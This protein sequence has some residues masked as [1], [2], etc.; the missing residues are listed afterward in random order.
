MVSGKFPGAIA[1]A[2]LLIV[3]TLNTGTRADEGMWPFNNV[4]KDEI[5]RRYGFTVTDAWLRKVQLA[6]VRFNNGGSGSFVS[7]DGLVLT[8]N[9]IAEDTLSKLSTPEKDY[10]KDGFLAR[11]RAEEARAPDLELNLLMSIEDVTARVRGATK[12]GM[13]AAEANAAREA[14][15][16]AIEDESNKA[17]GLRSDVV[18]L[19]QGGQYNLYRYKQYTDVR[20]VFAPEAAIGFFGGDPDNFEYPR[21]NL[22][23]A[24]FR[25][26]ENGQPLKVSNYFAWSRTGGREN[27][28]VFVSGNPGS[29]GRLNTVAHLRY[30]RD[31]GLPFQLKW[32]ANRLDA[33]RRYSAQGA[34]QA[35][36]AES[37]ILGLENSLK[38]WRGQL[39]GLRDKA[40]MAKRETAEAELRRMVEAD[41]G[42]RKEYGDA[43]E[44]IAGARKALASYERERRFLEST[45]GYK[46]AGFQSTLFDIARK[47]VRLASE[48]RKPNEERLADFTDAARETLEL[49]L[50]SSAP[51]YKDLEK[52]KLTASLAFMRDE[53]GAA[54]PL[55]RKAL[56]G[57]TPE[58]RAAEL[59]DGTKLADVEYRRQLAAGGI[60]AIESATDPMI[61]LA[62]SVDPEARAVRKRYTDEVEGVEH[63]AYA[64][65]SRALFDLNGTKMYPDA[66][67]TLRLAFGTIRGYRE[68]GKAVAAFTDFAGLYRR[69]A[70]HNNR[71]PYQ[72]PARWVERKSALDLKMPFNFAAALDSTGGNSGSPV[73][74]RDAELV[75]L[76]FD[77]NIQSLI[78]DYVYDETQNRSLCVDSRAMLE[79]LRRV[80]GANEIADELT[81]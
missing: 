24:L 44:A 76:L 41:P 27:E 31:T 2:A 58:A 56:A 6:S 1:A 33:L 38:L 17:T 40:I 39:E 66:T 20:L 79:A 23:M 63:D 19:Y 57:K 52:A 49:G 29:T 14:E 26:Y 81:R 16:K 15:I 61:V 47:L 50:Y 71:P 65:I 78:G 34:E 59:V 68:N 60:N 30:L 13:T 3:S 4:P 25:V 42:K 18:T 11:T 7:R 43:W 45:T 37:E 53:L 28:L 55:V 77:G 69:A 10:M 46:T 80:Y 51:L 36:R 21:Y 32:Y 8:N 75:G 64:K 72:L 9:H 67:F 62:R 70:E 35:R 74:N 12:P 48:S 73:I 22:D 54:N 5:K